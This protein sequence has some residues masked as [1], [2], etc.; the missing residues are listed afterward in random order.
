MSVS[1]SRATAQRALL[2]F[3]ARKLDD[4]VSEFVFNGFSITRCTVNHGC[5]LYCRC[6]VFA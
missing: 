3:A 4:L 5:R 1:G 2:E 6:D